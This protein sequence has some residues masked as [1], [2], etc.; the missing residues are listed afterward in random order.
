MDQPIK[1]AIKQATSSGSSC[2]LLSAFAPWRVVDAAATSTA[3]VPGTPHQHVGNRLTVA[4]ETANR[5]RA[6]PVA[7]PRAAKK[8]R[9]LSVVVVVTC[10]DVRALL[11]G[12]SLLFNA[13]ARSK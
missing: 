8:K 4:R 1:S 10:T 9:L 13:A 2:S 3:V 5:Y 6:T 7:V 11:V 12:P